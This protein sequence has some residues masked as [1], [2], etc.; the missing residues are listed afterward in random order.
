MHIS[1]S[2][3]VIVVDI[4]ILISYFLVDLYNYPFVGTSFVDYSLILRFS[5]AAASTTYLLNPDKKSI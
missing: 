4:Y 3:C 5:D 2:T 1:A